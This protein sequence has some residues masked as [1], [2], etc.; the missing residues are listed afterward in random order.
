MA[1][2][3]AHDPDGIH[4]RDCSGAEAP[5]DIQAPT[6]NWEGSLSSRLAVP[7]FLS[8]RYDQQG[9]SVMQYRVVEVLTRSLKILDE[10]GVSRYLGVHQGQVLS[11]GRRYAPRGQYAFG[12]LQD[13]GTT[14]WVDVE[15]TCFAHHGWVRNV[16]SPSVGR[17]IQ[18]RKAAP[19]RYDDIMS[20]LSYVTGGA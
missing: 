12:R 19:A 2:E 11:I 3:S 7:E 15:K 6:L 1:N 13:S 18:C 16:P 20:S 14:F 5:G 17:P 4:Y 8:T 10:P 9:F